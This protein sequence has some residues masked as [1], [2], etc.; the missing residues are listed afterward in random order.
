MS[1]E[2]CGAAVRSRE[3]TACAPLMLGDG[4]SC[5]CVPHGQVCDEMPSA[6]GIDLYQSNCESPEDQIPLVQYLGQTQ[7]NLCAFLDVYMVDLMNRSV[8]VGA[9]RP[10]DA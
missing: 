4:Q 1:L 8:F 7:K 10:D 2:D 6:A 9:R 3:A 5:R